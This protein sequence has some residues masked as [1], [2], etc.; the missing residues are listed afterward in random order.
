[1]EEDRCTFHVCFDSV[2][3]TSAV[4]LQFCGTCVKGAANAIAET[5]TVLAWCGCDGDGAASVRLPQC[6]DGHIGQ[7]RSGVCRVCVSN[8]SHRKAFSSS[9][10][11]LIQLQLFALIPLCQLKKS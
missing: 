6:W 9:G 2:F 5:F 11:M 1:M 8:R 3:L 7:F 10:Y 4:R